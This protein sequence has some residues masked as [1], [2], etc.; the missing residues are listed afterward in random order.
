MIT[1]EQGRYVADH[2]PG[3]RFVEVPGNARAVA[4]TLVGAEVDR[5]QFKHGWAI[6]TFGRPFSSMRMRYKEKTEVPRATFNEVQS[7]RICLT[8]ATGALETGRARN[9]SPDPPN[10]RW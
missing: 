8:Q 9:L 2:I 5:K 10:N 4:T 7:Q 1:I 6:Q 3:A